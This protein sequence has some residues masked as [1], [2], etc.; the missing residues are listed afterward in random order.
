MLLTNIILVLAFIIMI[1]IGFW[2]SMSG[3]PS[4]PS[5]DSKRQQVRI[6][7]TETDADRKSDDK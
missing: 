6:I 5:S 4:R 2:L 1:G 3:T 7:D